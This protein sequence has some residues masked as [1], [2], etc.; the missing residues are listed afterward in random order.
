MSPSHDIHECYYCGLNHKTVEAGGIY[1]CPNAL[2][3][4]PGAAHFRSQLKS[5]C[6]VDGG[7]KH[8]VDH[9]EAIAAALALDVEPAIRKAIEASI[10]RWRT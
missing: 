8:T 3:Q 5:Y 2:C 6:E 4:G 1:Y 7:G 10:P 9:E